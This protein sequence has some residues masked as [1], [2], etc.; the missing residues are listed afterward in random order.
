RRC[1]LPIR[2]FVF[3]APQS[4]P[5]ANERGCPTT[6]E[7]IL[8]NQEGLNPAVSEGVGATGRTSFQ[9]FLPLYSPSKITNSKVKYSSVGSVPWGLPQGALYFSLMSPI[10]T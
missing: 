2:A 1:C 9:S 10:W 7:A 8:Y 3:S 5:S 4:T 6:A